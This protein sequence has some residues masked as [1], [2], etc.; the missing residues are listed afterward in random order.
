MG[1]IFT[2]CNL[3]FFFCKMIK[4]LPNSSAQWVIN[5]F[6][7]AFY[8]YW[9]IVCSFVYTALRSQWASC[10]HLPRMHACIIKA[11]EPVP[12][13]DGPLSLYFW[14][15]YWVP[16][17]CII[18][19][20]STHLVYRS[21]P[22]LPQASKAVQ[23]HFLLPCT[24]TTISIYEG[25]PALSILVLLLFQMK[26]CSIICLEHKYSTLSWYLFIQNVQNCVCCRSPPACY[27]YISFH[28]SHL[29]PTWHYF[30]LEPSHKGQLFFWS[31]FFPADRLVHDP[32]PL[33]LGN[34]AW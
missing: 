13:T 12:Y 16:A 22:P 5:R 14:D 9:L 4:H 17:M 3:V 8:W 30:K 15:M 2:L 18:L 31:I 24:K 34:G 25:R 10:T 20:F 26:L 7:W 32:V 23:P 11:S 21:P 19:C 29:P 6:L 27:Y 33:A 1:N 28:Y